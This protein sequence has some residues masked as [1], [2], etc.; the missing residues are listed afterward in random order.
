MTKKEQ[1]MQFQCNQGLVRDTGLF[2][3]AVTKV[4]QKYL[5]FPNEK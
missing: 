1:K 5:T 3:G 4:T 2:W